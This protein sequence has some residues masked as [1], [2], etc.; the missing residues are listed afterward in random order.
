M[1]LKL[2]FIGFGNVA[3][4]FARMLES[5]R[6][7]LASE[8]DLSWQAVAIATARHGSILSDEDIDLVEAAEALEAGASLSAFGGVRAARDALEVVEQCRADILFETT[9]LD[10]MGGEPAVTFIRKALERGIHVVTAN[11]GPVAFAHRELKS[12]ASRKRVC[13]RFEGTVMDG[14]PVFNLYEYCLPCANILGFAGVLNSTTNLILDGMGEGRSFEESLLEAQKMGVAE[15]NADYDIEGWDASLKAVVLAR[16]LMGAEV[17]PAEVAREGIRGINGDDVR[18][19]L[20]QGLA[21]RLVARGL[22]GEDRVKLSVAAERVLL[23]SSLGSTRGTT[24]A[25]ILQTD[26]LGDLTI[27]ETRPGVEQTAY[28][29]LSDMLAIRRFIGGGEYSR[30]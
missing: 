20:E 11:K 12:I 13:F 21:I 10:P 25:L 7:R 16:V 30:R 24:N 2:A 29:L 19:A 6:E 14:A 18:S 9:T 4:A 17:L 15:A 22:K 28:A 5:Q 26:V 27:V 3:R 8:F 23:E 1:E